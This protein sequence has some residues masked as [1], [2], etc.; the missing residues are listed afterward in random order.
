MSRTWSAS[1]RPVSLDGLKVVIDCANGAAYLAGP[2][3]PSRLGCRR[4][5]DPRRAR[6]ASTSTTTAGPPTWTLAAAVL[7]HRA[8]LGIAL[9]GDA[10][11]CL[12]VDADGKIVDGDQILAILALALRDGGRLP[13]DTV[14]AT[15]MSNL[16]F[17]QAMREPGSPSSRPRSATATCS[18]R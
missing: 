17:V 3:A 1:R 8:D 7:E 13:D 15:V 16:G 5:P 9:D 18:R 6:T 12:A 11:R 2:G 4:D 14:V 10:D